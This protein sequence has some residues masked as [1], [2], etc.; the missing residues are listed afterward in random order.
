MKGVN[1][2]EKT[3]KI[4]YFLG[5]FILIMVRRNVSFNEITRN[6]KFACFHYWIQKVPNLT[7][8]R[9]TK[10]TL[11]SYDNHRAW[12]EEARPKSTQA[13]TNQPHGAPRYLSHL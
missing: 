4:I 6:N 11:A 12:E 10:I 9:E 5:R 1:Q 3:R 13:E 7:V 8:E 2:T